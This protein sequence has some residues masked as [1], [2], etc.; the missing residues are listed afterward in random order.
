[1]FVMYLASLETYLENIPLAEIVLK[2]KPLKV[3]AFQVA[4][5]P[6]KQHVMIKID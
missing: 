1:M 5:S 2:K 4:K 3:S 6:F